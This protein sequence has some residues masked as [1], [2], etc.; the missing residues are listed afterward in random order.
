MWWSD[1]QAVLRLDLR[2]LLVVLLRGRE[3]S[4]AHDGRT[5]LPIVEIKGIPQS[6]LRY[7]CEAKKVQAR[8]RRGAW[9]IYLPAIRKLVEE[10]TCDETPSEIELEFQ[11][12]SMRPARPFSSALDEDGK[13]KR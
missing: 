12:A 13:R 3:V 10:A 4:E 11:E 9:E 2:G 6:T 1:G 7:W 8:K 5:W